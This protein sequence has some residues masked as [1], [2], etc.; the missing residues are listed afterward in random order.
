M[1]L[2]MD[3]MAM[4]HPSFAM[5]IGGVQIEGKLK[6]LITDVEVEDSD[7]EAD[8]ARIVVADINY[9]FSTALTITDSTTVVISI[10][11]D[12]HL[13]RKFEGVVTLTE[14]SFGP[15]GIPMLTITAMDKSVDMATV[16]KTREWKKSKISTVVAAIAKEYGYTAKVK[17]TVEIHDTI[18]Q[19]RETD[20]A[21]FTRFA[22]NEAFQW[23]IIEETKELY[24]GERLPETATAAETFDYDTGNCA[25]IDFNPVRVEKTRTVSTSSAL[26]AKSGVGGTSNSGTTKPPTTSKV[27]TP[28]GGGGRSF[29]VASTDGDIVTRV[30]IRGGRSVE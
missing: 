6:E 10:G 26:D 13:V 27:V 14:G 19:D 4:L 1:T 9:R 25:V 7:A 8:V 20:A 3:R 15:D 11:Y 2:L 28:K 18:T 17:D 16:L 5:R 22:E 21:A 30:T 23:F 29:G 12:G 24:F